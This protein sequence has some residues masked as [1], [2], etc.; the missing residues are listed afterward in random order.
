M[1]GV[2]RYN[3]SWKLLKPLSI[4]LEFPSSFTMSLHAPFWG[5]YEG[6]VATR[7]LIVFITYTYPIILLCQVPYAIILNLSHFLEVGVYAW[8]PNCSLP[9]R[10]LCCTPECHYNVCYMCTC[11]IIYEGIHTYVTA[12]QNTQ[13]HDILVSVRIELRVLL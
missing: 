11:T 9:L 7:N 4:R 6:C 12:M 1:V 5:H 10:L 2:Q 8:S 3:S 13:V